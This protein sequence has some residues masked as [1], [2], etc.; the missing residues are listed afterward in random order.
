MK[1]CLR[2]IEIKFCLQMGKKAKVV[3][4]HSVFLGL[5]LI[6]GKQCAFLW[7]KSKK[8]QTLFRGHEVPRI[9]LDSKD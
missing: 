3:V 6:F 7:T 4:E 2:A 5:D 9:I 1:I 8:F